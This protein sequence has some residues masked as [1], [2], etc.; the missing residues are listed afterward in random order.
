[1]TDH[2]CACTD[3]YCDC[4]ARVAGVDMACED[5]MAGAHDLADDPSMDDEGDWWDEPI[6]FYLDP[7]DYGPYDED[8]DPYEDDE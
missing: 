5:C 2:R 1:M 3:P 6:N 4:Y 8:Y 7:L